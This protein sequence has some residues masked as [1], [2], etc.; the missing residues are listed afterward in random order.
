MTDSAK[1]Q[2]ASGQAPTREFPAPPPTQAQERE[3]TPDKHHQAT[4]HHQTTKHQARERKFAPPY[5]GQAGERTFAPSDVD[6]AREREFSPPAP[7]KP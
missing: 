5:P 6:Q 4:K 7:K 3:F 1:S 2:S